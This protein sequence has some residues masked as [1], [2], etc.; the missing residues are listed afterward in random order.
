[1]YRLYSS[2]NTYAMSAHAI[3]EELGVAYELVN[4]RLFSDDPDPGFLAAS[5]HGRVPALA[6]PDGPV[7]ETGAIALYLADKHPEAGLAIP[8]GDP[9]RA[10]FLQWLFYLSST[11]QPEVL[12]QFHPEFYFPDAG[13]Q[14]RLKAASVTRL[15]TVLGVLDGALSP[16]P[17]FFGDRLTVCDICLATQAVWPEIYPGTIDGYPNLKRAVEQAVARPAVA[18]VL[19][20]HEEDRARL[21]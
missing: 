18:R 21:P 10:L 1:M 6:T 11:L 12:I 9:R 13:D 4:V 16:G 17:F 20:R 3:L 15:G 19:A 2:P 7:C 14:A 5:P 8:A